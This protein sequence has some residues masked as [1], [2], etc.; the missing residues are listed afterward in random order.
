MISDRA[1]L[2]KKMAAVRMDDFPNDFPI[3]QHEI[4]QCQVIHCQLLHCFRC[5]KTSSRFGNLDSFV[6]STDSFLAH[7]THIYIHTYIYIYI[8]YLGKFLRPHWD[9][10]VTSPELWL[11]SRESREHYIPITS[12]IIQLSELWQFIHIYIYVYSMYIYMYM[13]MYMYIYIYIFIYI[14]I[15]IQYS[16]YIYISYIYTYIHCIHIYIYAIY[17]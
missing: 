16:D 3:L 1:T 2:W 8:Y 7:D 11:E 14:Y 17:M 5:C 13:Y 15:Y 4:S 6:F 9:L 10:T 12:I